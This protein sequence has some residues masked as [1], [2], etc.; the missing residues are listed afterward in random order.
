MALQGGVMFLDGSQ[1]LQE[2]S[3]VRDDKLRTLFDD[4][5]QVSP[6]QQAVAA[7]CQAGALSL[8]SLIHSPMCGFTLPSE[9]LDRALVAADFPADPTTTMDQ[10]LFCSK[11]WDL[12]HSI[13]AV[14][15]DKPLVITRLDG[16]SIKVLLEDE[17][18]FAM[19]AEN[20]FTEL[21][22][23]DTGKI[24]PVTLKAALLQMGL[25]MGIPVPSATEEAEPLISLILEKHKAVGE[26]GQAQFAKL[27]QE[28]LE[29]LAEH[30]A[31]HPIAVILDVNVN[32]GSEL[33]KLLADVELFSKVSD[34]MFDD[35][36]SSRDGKLSRNELRHALESHGEEWGL[37]ARETNEHV[38][39]LYNDL[40]SACDGDNSGEIDK[41][42]FQ[43]LLREILQ[44]FAEKLEKNPV[45]VS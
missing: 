38:A 41:K 1:I 6:T 26:I 29:D 23:E 24:S 3:V 40:F 18:D 44:V 42:E 13:A 11:I 28:I 36:D 27:L 22:V 8:L 17:D 15:K 35:F 45:F 10:A 9:L 21:D 12:W 2:L 19:L 5:V 37:P 39:Q 14:L 20:L 33:K 43:S 4:A 32:N 25:E 31:L 7:Q 16:T 30:L 34:K